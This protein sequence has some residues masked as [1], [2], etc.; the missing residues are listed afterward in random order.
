MLIF[1]KGERNS[2]KTKKVYELY[3]CLKQNGISVSGIISIAEMENN[4]K[5]N[6]YALNL[7]DN[8]KKLLASKDNI[9]SGKKFGG[10]YFYEDGFDY[11]EKVLMENIED[12]VKIIDEVGRLEIN[13]GGF[14]KI[15]NFLI[16]NYRGN[17]ILVVRS[18]NLKDIVNTF[19]LK[20][21]SEIEIKGSIVEDVM[22]KLK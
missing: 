4:V 12:R 19:C 21:Y 18:S 8:E 20:E 10:Y 5:K 14:Y 9:C 7:Y 15:L 17:L 22:I 11:S 3:Q 6:Y 16:K 1:L 2:G 13:K